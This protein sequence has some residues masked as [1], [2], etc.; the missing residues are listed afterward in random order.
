MISISEGFA[1]TI[2]AMLLVPL[3]VASCL[4]QY[5]Y[6]KYKRAQDAIAYMVEDEI[7]D[8]S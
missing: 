7:E 2:L 8:D 4:A 3:I 5:Y 1:T 6:D